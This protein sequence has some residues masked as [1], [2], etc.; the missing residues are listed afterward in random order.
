MVSVYFMRLEENI[1]PEQAG[2]WLRRMPQQ[3]IYR[4][5]NF[6]HWEDACCHLYGRVLLATALS[7]HGKDPGL[8]HQLCY[9]EYQKPYLAGGGMNFSIAHS[10]TLV[11]CAFSTTARMGLDIEKVVDTDIND[12]K[13]IFDA[14]EWEHITSQ[15][16]PIAGFYRL[17][18]QKE[19]VIKGCG[20][21][22]SLDPKAVRLNGSGC[23]LGIDRWQL[24]ELEL[25]PGY[26]AC[27]AN[28]GNEPEPYKLVEVLCTAHK[29]ECRQLE[30]HSLEA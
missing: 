25:A 3:T 6:W 5:N 9:S 16:E 19:A 8:I 10:G 14:A 21:G 7:A 17:W 4:F 13:N 26:S 12:F 24:Q 1:H 2:Y 30:T 18:V 23:R 11:S 29:T 15:S 22:W 20:H 27:L 28:M